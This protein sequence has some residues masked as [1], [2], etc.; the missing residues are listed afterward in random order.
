MIKTQNKGEGI[1]LQQGIQ[2]LHQ[3][4]QE[5]LSPAPTHSAYLT[6]LR[7][8]AIPPT[9]N[10]RPALELCGMLFLPGV[11]PRPAMAKLSTETAAKKQRLPECG[12]I[13]SLVRKKKRRCACT[14]LLT[15]HPSYPKLI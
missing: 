3:D 12:M 11:L 14:L 7:S 6:E 10:C 9:G 4:R 13:S 1:A 2:G 5:H 8:R 15:V